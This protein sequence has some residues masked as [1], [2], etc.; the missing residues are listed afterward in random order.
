MCLPIE[1]RTVTSTAT[2]RKWHFVPV[3][4]ELSFPETGAAI[5]SAYAI[6]PFKSQKLHALCIILTAAYDIC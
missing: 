6:T 3:F 2:L 4:S 5:R 1:I